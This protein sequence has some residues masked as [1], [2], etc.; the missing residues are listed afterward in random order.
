[1]QKLVNHIIAYLDYLR[2]I[3]CWS[4]TI[5]E[6]QKITT[7]YLTQFL[8]YRVHSN[9]YC[10]YLKSYAEIW[11][12][13][14]DK[15]IKLLPLLENG[16]FWGTCHCG[17][18][19]YVYP[20]R[21]LSPEEKVIGFI[22]VS[23][24]RS[25]TEAADGKLRH[26]S[27]KYDLSYE[28]IHSLSDAHLSAEY[29]DTTL[30]NT[31]LYPLSSMLEQLYQKECLLYGGTPEQAQDA[32]YLLNQILLFIEKNFHRQ[33]TMNDIC[34]AF[35]CSRSYVGHTF[36]AST[37]CNFREYINLLRMEEAKKL[38]ANTSFSITEISLKAGYSNPNYFSLLFHRMNGMPPLEYRKGYK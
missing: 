36:K 34:T 18:T 20:I 14:I 30:L 35:H 31:L 28:F 17:V 26:I 38:L 7:P 3:C 24:Y 25:C 5:H 22:S 15:Q 29:P 19:E 2:N 13:C 9:P 27:Q 12:D 4:I 21:Q 37:G 23:G 11:D 8:P 10:I 33:I 16:P 1:M 32:D 6:F